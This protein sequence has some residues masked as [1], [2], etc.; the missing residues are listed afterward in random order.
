MNKIEY[1]KNYIKS[2][3]FGLALGNLFSF[4]KST[5]LLG[6]RDPSEEE[7]AST[8]LSNML[9]LIDQALATNTYINNDI[10]P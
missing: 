7:L 9:I 1:I 6:V 10:L 3:A 5:A 2:T 8:I 4:S